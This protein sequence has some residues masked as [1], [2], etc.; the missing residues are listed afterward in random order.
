M[1]DGCNAHTAVILIIPFLQIYESTIP[2]PD[3]LFIGL[4]TVGLTH[5]RHSLIQLC[6][7]NTIRAE[8]WDRLDVDAFRKERERGD[9]E[10]VWNKVKAF[11]EEKQN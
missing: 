4:S 5:Q 1:D 2:Q 3:Q 9:F 8:T 7:Y 10:A 11:C 6:L